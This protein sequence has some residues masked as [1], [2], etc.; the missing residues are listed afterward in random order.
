MH[1]GQ[2]L[3]RPSRMK[4][5]GN[6]KR[7]KK[8]KRKEDGKKQETYAIE[9]DSDGSVRIDRCCFATQRYNLAEDADGLVSESLKILGV[10]ARRSFRGCH[11][12]FDSVFKTDRVANLGG[13]GIER[14]AL[15]V[16]QGKEG[17]LRP[18]SR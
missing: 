9:V 17:A 3:G 18:L 1:A 10:Y 12:F 16:R 15:E 4:K 13:G 2:T 5:Q 6:L 7:K 14:N 11:V 8:K